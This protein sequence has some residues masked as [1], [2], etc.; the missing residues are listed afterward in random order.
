MNKSTS[1][2]QSVKLQNV[3]TFQIVHV[4]TFDEKL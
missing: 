2:N 1:Y 3:V 4:V